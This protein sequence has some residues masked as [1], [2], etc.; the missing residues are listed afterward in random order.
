M[1]GAL[2]LGL[3]MT[4][5]SATAQV[6]TGPRGASEFT[7]LCEEAEGTGFNWRN[8][9][10]VK[11][12]FV[13]EKL[14]VRKLTSF[15][16]GEQP[17]GTFVRC[18]DFLKGEPFTADTIAWL[19]GCYRVGKLGQENPTTAWCTEY[20]RKPGKS[21]ALDSVVCKADDFPA[22]LSFRPDGAFTYTFTH[23]NVDPKPK[24]DYK[25]SL[26]ISHGKCSTIK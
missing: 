8:G 18:F 15:E 21:W 16:Q 12:Q 3:L 7:S 10:W 26:K 20:Y 5:S 23:S 25:D 22:E 9:G 24:D 11:T 17:D 2:V 13:E 19:S 14:I 1:R 4:C 6:A